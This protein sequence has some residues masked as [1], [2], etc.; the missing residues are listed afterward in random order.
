MFELGILLP[1]SQYEIMFLNTTLTD[2]EIEYT[3]ESNLKVLNS[4]KQI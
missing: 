2:E 1:P 4:I 3:I